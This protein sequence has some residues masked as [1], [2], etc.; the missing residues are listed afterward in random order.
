MILIAK[1]SRW[2]GELRRGILLEGGVRLA[3]AGAAALVGLAWLDR[4]FV[5]PQD[6]RLAVLGAG[7]LA[8]LAGAHRLLLRPWRQARWEQVFEGA[9]RRHPELRDYL[10]S[11][12]QLRE[13]SQPRHTSAALARAHV[14]RAEALLARLPPGPVFR[15]SPSPAARRLAVSAGLAALTLPWLGG[16]A[17][18]RILSPWR[19]VPLETL[20]SVSPG[21][22]K[23]DWGKLAVIQVRLRERSDVLKGADELTLWLKAGGGWKAASWDHAARETAAFMLAELNEPLDYRLTWRDMRSADY[24]LTP[25]PVPQLTSLKARL[26]GGGDQL[27]ALSVAEPLAARRGS[28]IVLSGRPNEPLARALLRLSFLPVPVALKPGAAGE[29]EA[30]FFALEDGTFQLDLEAADGRRDPA[31]MTF[32]LKALPDDPPT[33]DLLSPSAPLQASPEDT[34]PIAYAAKDDSGLRRIS[35]I[36]RPAIGAGE[37]EIELQ[38]FE[39]ARPDFLG[40]Y[41][42][43]L[44]G[45]PPGARIEFQLKALDD[46]RSP[47]AGFSAKGVIEIVD[48][49]KGHRQAQQRWLAVERSLRSL[50]ER[51]ERVRDLAGSPAAVVEPELA[52]LP[53]QW[54]KTAQDMSQL[55]EA[56]SQDAYA[57]PGLNEEFASLAEQLQSAA[58][59]EV[60]AAVKASRS[61]DAGEARRRHGRLAR[62]LRKAQRLLQD[63]RGLQGLQDFYTEAGRMSR[64]SGELE[65]ALEGMAGLKKGQAAPEATARLQASLQKLQQQMESL[66][67]AIAALPKPSPG[68]QE[69][70]SRKGYTM[71]LLKAQTAA[72]ALQQALKRGD[73]AMA[74]DIARELSQQLAAI[75]KAIGQASAAASAGSEGGPSAASSEKIEK[76]QALWR[77]LI[78]DQSRLIEESQRLEEAR[79]KGVVEAQKDMLAELAAEQAAL[80]SSAAARGSGFPAEALTPMRA[81]LAEFESRQVSR[82]SVHLRAALARLRF[83]PALAYFADA[84]EAIIKRLEAPQAGPPA[85]AAKA[86]A[87]AR[88]QG[89]VREKTA[90]LQA[91]LE[92][93]ESEVGPMPPEAVEKVEAAQGEQ[94]AAEEALARGDSGAGLT[95]QQSAL[96]L[97]EQGGQ[98]LNNSAEA[99]QSISNGKGQPFQRPGSGV[100]RAGSGSARLDPVPLPSAKDYRPPKEIRDELERS[101]RESRPP[102]YDEVI[103][104][105]FKRISQ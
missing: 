20:V 4:A 76:T 83:D 100:R 5:L 33:I 55:S 32:S 64:R 38:R 43:A 44:A 26:R 23:L 54:K 31:P 42:W 52:G 89:A 40:D 12:W 75:E 19:D 11:A 30:G 93:L 39:A 25:V 84:E 73:Y 14:E 101:L 34:I 27:V 22:A 9:S 87:A 28:W 50:A 90:R 104:E 41:S 96:S 66:A 37:H 98:Q 61:A 77:E 94:R 16:R 45:L 47:Q 35:L 102:V 51:E 91:Q 65:A 74:A 85:D 80:V 1:A 79:L 72:D 6:A 82:A 71:P 95:R 69:D 59:G 17:W 2:R 36:L 62:Q 8:V 48:F 60:P 103:K 86:A 29:L 81:A 63:G 53:E 97:L 24:R 68:S 21:T 70:S 49:E 10:A 78:E 15:W 7:G 58:A 105:Y 3:C 46:A 99:H 67:A 56:M 57:N 92:E 88:R 18:V 13:V